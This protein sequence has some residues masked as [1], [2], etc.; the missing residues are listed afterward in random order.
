MYTEF[1]NTNYLNTIHSAINMAPRER[2][3]KDYDNISRKTNDEIN[4]CFL[5]KVVRL[6]KSDSTISLNSMIYEVPQQFIKKYITLKYNPEEISTL[7]IYNEKNERLHE[8]KRVDKISNSNY[9]RQELVS[10][11]REENIDNV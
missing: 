11:Y 7:Y 9:K 2:F 4:E 5:H 6:V 3:M 10:L 1:L 8:I